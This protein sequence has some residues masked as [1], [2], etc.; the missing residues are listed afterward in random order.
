MTLTTYLLRMSSVARLFVARGEYSQWPPLTEIMK[1][2]SAV[3]LLFFFKCL[4]SSEFLKSRKSII[5]ISN[6]NSST[7]WTLPPGP[8][9][10]YPH[11]LR[12]NPVSVGL[13]P[14]FPRAW[15]ACRGTTLPFIIESQCQCHLLNF[16]C[17]YIVAF[18]IHTSSS[19]AAVHTVC[20]LQL[21][22]DSVLCLI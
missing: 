3:C 9:H 17:L 12:S 13:P 19:T 16:R 10:H 20:S 7:P 1:F 2:E 4:N 8:R 21:H 11:S 18:E 14:L 22:V 5:C 6:I 15:M